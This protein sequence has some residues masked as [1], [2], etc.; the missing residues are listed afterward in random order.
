MNVGESYRGY[1]PLDR[2]VNMGVSFFVHP[3]LGVDPSRFQ[4]KPGMTVSEL[5][6]SHLIARLFG[7]HG[8]IEN[9]VP[10]FFNANRRLHREVELFVEDL[11]KQGKEVSYTVSAK[12]GDHPSI[13]EELICVIKA[14]GQPLLTI[15]IPNVP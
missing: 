15:P 6:R 10:L 11:A 9:I 13:P 4:I 8:E 14:E 3:F 1:Y 7:G 2:P 5:E 12:Y